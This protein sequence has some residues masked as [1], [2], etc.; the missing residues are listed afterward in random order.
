MS[1]ITPWLRTCALSV[2][3]SLSTPPGGMMVRS[4]SGPAARCGSVPSTRCQSVRTGRSPGGTF[5]RRRSSGSRSGAARSGTPLTG[6]SPVSVLPA[7]ALPTDPNVVLEL[8]FPLAA[9]ADYCIW[10]RRSSVDPLAREVN[11]A[12][13]LTKLFDPPGETSVGVLADESGIRSVGLRYE[14]DVE[15]AVQGVSL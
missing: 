11:R 12:S 14:N 8:K 1:T 3:G 4:S 7:A 9:V 2:V 5:S 10:S 13:K 15:S 6:G